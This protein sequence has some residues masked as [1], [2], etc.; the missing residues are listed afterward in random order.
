MPILL[1]EVITVFAMQAIIIVGNNQGKEIEFP[2]VLVIL[3]GLTISM[4][5]NQSVMTHFTGGSEKYRE[6]AYMQ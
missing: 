1:S 3:W 2:M 5:L 4:M 6:K